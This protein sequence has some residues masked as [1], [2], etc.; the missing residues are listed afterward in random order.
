M[1]LGINKHILKILVA[2]GLVA[3]TLSGLFHKLARAEMLAPPGGSFYQLSGA[4]EDSIEGL[5]YPVEENSGLPVTQPPA[6]S[7]LY[8][9][10]PANIKDEVDYNTETGEYEVTRKVAGYNYQTPIKMSAEEYSEYSFRK[11]KRE[12]WQKQSKP[13]AAD[14]E[15]L[16]FIPAINIKG[17]A[18]DKIFG[19]SVISIVPQGSAE[20]I[21]GFSLSTSEDPTLSE[22]A[23]RQPS[24]DFDEKI[25]MNVTGSVGE[26]VQLGINYNT[27]ATFD[28]ENKT[29][30]EYAG[31][32]DDI[33]Q[34]IEL[35]N[36]TMPL[37]GSLITGSQSLFGAKTELKFGKLSVT[38]VFSRQEGQ[39][40]VIEIEG[41]AQ[42]SEF[43]V[44]IA[45]YDA[46]RHF[47]LSHYFQENYDRALRNYPILSTSVQIEEIE[48]WVTN[49]NNKVEGA[50]N[51]VAFLDLGEN[52]PKYIQNKK[53]IR[54]AFVNPWEDTK[55]VP[56][57]NELNKVYGSFNDTTAAIRSLSSLQDA[58]TA[59][60]F[61]FQEALDYEKVQNAR[62]LDPR[63]Y[64]INKQLGYI[65]LNTALNADE[66]LAVA[67][68]YRFTSGAAD[69]VRAVHKVGELSKYIPSSEKTLIV[70]L[71]KGTN[72]T[73]NF[74]NWNLMM[75]NVYALGAYQVNEQDFEL[76]ILYQ[77]DRQGQPINYLPE[78][79]L[80]EELLLNV[81]GFD[82]L[83]FLGEQGS[84]GIFDFE[85]GITIIPSNGRIIFPTVEPFDS[86]L[87]LF[88]QKPIKT[89]PIP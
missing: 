17:E 51:I 25:M 40:S 67:Y 55:S 21:F 69:D 41:G 19:S 7:P 66:I 36:V 15:N 12:Y 11:A 46:N 58:I 28:F 59:T 79:R 20:L 61:D 78:G 1:G 43:E 83:N 10:D 16:P 42:V 34:K 50:R 68:S 38:S 35:G 45:D 86:T 57:E 70:K 8:L 60:G 80:D 32:E 84:D 73:P 72:L 89:A 26:R 87:E 29:K 82:K 9:K 48:V 27:E 71:L 37:T 88:L 44:Q 39:S 56:P 81:F 49:N 75:K 47:F 31:E 6:Q 13:S 53:V 2:G 4:E 54:D 3:I 33:I 14:G 22:K 62:K 64:T 65:S 30:L 23:R 77:D 18:F 5:R 52:N 63:E 74:T 85:P 76:N 24:F